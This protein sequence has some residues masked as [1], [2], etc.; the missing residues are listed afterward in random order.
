MQTAGSSLTAAMGRMSAYSG[1]PVTWDFVTKE[2]KLDTFK[3]D[4]ALGQT[5]ESPG[6]A[7]PGK[8]KLT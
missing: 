6:A 1:K 8:W 2:S 3:Q 5:I 7:V 4:I